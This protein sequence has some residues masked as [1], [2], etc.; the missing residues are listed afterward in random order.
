MGL[1]VRRRTVIVSFTF[2]FCATRQLGVVLCSVFRYMKQRF[3]LLQ[4]TVELP[5]GSCLLADL[6]H[7]RYV[8]CVLQRKEWS[9]KVEVMRAPQNCCLS[10]H[11][12]V[13]TNIN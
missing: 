7:L 9:S 1:F 4:A 2:Y 13:V 8:G 12:A 3:K 5:E 11:A 6:G 10:A